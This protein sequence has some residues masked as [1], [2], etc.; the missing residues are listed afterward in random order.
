M[1]HCPKCGTE[2]S[3]EMVF[4]P[5]CGAAL[6]AEGAREQRREYR[7]DEKA[8]KAE[9]EEKEEKHEKGEKYEKR[10]VGVVGPLI[11]AFIGG[12]AL[13]LFGLMLY[14]HFHGYRILEFGWAAFLVIIGLAIIIGALYA[15]GVAKKRHP[16]A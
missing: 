8:E 10:E 5:K 6:K 13:I 15:T 7:R 2:V 3:E 1:A 11:G 9:K 12:F 4:C 16:P 14:L